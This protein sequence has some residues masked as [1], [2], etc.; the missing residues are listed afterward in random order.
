[1][2]QIYVFII[3]NDVWIYGLTIV[4]L[5]WYLRELWQARSQLRGAMFGLERERGQ[6][7]Q[8]RALVLIVICSSIIAIVT[9]VNLQVAPTL[10]AELLKPPT[11]T[12][13]IFST[14]LSS[15]TPQNPAGLAPTPQ[16]APTATLPEQS[17]AII[18]PDDS[19]TADDTNIPESTSTPA[20]I[21]SD[22]PSNAQ[23]TSPPSGALTSGALTIFG[24][25]DSDDFGSY[26]IDALGPQT[27]QTWLP[28]LS[29]EGQSVVLDGI[30]ASTNISN[31]LPGN[32]F[33]RLRI[34][35]SAEEQVDECTIEIILG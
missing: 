22:C 29:D 25:A 33:V 26:L 16:L 31:W 11:P 4:G 1:M 13:D 30:L 23:I 19:P 10:P 18:T 35:N 21:I 15:P 27:G 20:V 5:I 2:D 32:Y 12:P 7:L 6:R 24:T 17:G 9:Y 8:S 14:P 3:K 28:I 34:F